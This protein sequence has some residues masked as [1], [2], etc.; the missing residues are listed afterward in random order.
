MTR[1]G[2]NPPPT[3]WKADMLTTK[4]SLRSL[5]ILLYIF[6]DLGEGAEADNASSSPVRQGRSVKMCIAT[7]KIVVKEI[8]V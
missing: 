4:P 2:L 5:H 3:A 1:L 6:Q 7:R 8:L